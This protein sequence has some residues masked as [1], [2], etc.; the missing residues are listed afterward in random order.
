MVTFSHPHLHCQPHLVWRAVPRSYL[1]W[2]H[3]LGHLGPINSV[4]SV[5][6]YQFCVAAQV[7]MFLQGSTYLFIYYKFV[8]SS[9]MFKHLNM[10]LDLSWWSV[11]CSG[12]SDNILTGNS[13]YPPP[14]LNF[15]SSQTTL[16]LSYSKVSLKYKITKPNTTTRR[17][18]LYNWESVCTNIMGYNKLWIIYALCFL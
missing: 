14:R 3:N 18:C 16:I 2:R 1:V 15:N 5:Y 8:K 12:S 4:L 17:I 11:L 9:G 6:H 7:T 13:T 10:C